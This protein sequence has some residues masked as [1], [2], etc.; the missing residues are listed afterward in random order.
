MTSSLSV[1]HSPV[2]PQR[3][4]ELGREEKVERGDRGDLGEK[5]ESPKGERAIKPV[6]TLISKNGY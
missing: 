2:Y 4:T 1:L 6:I 3:F 5:K